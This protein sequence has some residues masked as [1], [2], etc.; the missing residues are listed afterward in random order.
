VAWR[1]AIKAPMPTP[2]EGA[3]AATKTKGGGKKGKKRAKQ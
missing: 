1:T 3:T 2:N